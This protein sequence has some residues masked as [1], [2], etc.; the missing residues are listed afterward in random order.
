MLYPRAHM[1][2]DAST[3]RLPVNQTQTTCEA[4]WTM[5]ATLGPPP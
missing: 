1:P 2:S 4:N 3:T 5:T